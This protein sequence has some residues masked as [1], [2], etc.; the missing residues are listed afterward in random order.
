VRIPHDDH[1]LRLVLVD[2]HDRARVALARRLEGHDRLSLAGHTGDPV[3]AHQLVTSHAPHVALV[4]PIRDDKQGYRLL[5]SLSA[6][7]HERRPVVIAHLSYY[8]PEYW[9]LARRAGA[10]D[11]ILKQINIAK[12]ADRLIA[13]VQQALPQERWPDILH[14]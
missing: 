1:R 2:D 9:E 6:I 3:E 10:A 5:S 4:D 12:L 11:L 8:Q 7:T 14:S 13:A